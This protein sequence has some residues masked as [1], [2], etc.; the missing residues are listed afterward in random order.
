MDNN[1]VA[2]YGTG[3]AARFL[4]MDTP[5]VQFFIETTRLIGGKQKSNHKTLLRI[6]IIKI[7]RNIRMNCIY[8]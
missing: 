3:L 5:N 2:I 6:F 4:G 7:M 1:Q 8:Y